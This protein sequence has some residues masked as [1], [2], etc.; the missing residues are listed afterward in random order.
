MADSTA[1]AKKRKKRSTSAT[2]TRKEPPTVIPEDECTTCSICQSKLVMFSGVSK[3]KLS[4]YLNTGKVFT[5][6]NIRCKACG[7]SLCHLRDLSKS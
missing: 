1:G 5:N 6:S 7:S 4:D 2:S 3:Y